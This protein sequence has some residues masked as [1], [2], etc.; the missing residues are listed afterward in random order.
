VDNLR[1]KVSAIIILVII[2][3]LLLLPISAF[4]LYTPNPPAEA[5]GYPEEQWGRLVAAMG[6]ENFYLH[7]DVAKFS[8]GINANDSFH[9]QPAGKFFSYLAALWGYC[10]T[11]GSIVAW[12]A[13]QGYLINNP[14]L[15]PSDFLD[16]Y[17]ENWYN[18]S[19]NVKELI[20]FANLTSPPSA[21]PPPPGET[22][23][24]QP[25]DPAAAP[26]PPDRMATSSSAQ[27]TSK[28]DIF[29]Y[30]HYG[31]TMRPHHF[32]NIYRSTVEE[33]DGKSYN[34]IVG[35]EGLETPTIQKW[36]D[37]KDYIFRDPIDDKIDPVANREDFETYMGHSEA[38]IFKVGCGSKGSK[39]MNWWMSCYV[40][41]LYVNW[42][43]TYKDG[44]L[45]NVP[46][47]NQFGKD[48]EYWLSG[49]GGSQY[50]DPLTAALVAEKYPQVL[51]LQFDIEAYATSKPPEDQEGNVA[52]DM[53]EVVITATT[54]SG[55]T[56]DEG[57]G[58]P[59]MAVTRLDNEIVNI[60]DCIN[61][62]TFVKD[63]GKNFKCTVDKPGRYAEDGI[64]A[65]E[66]GH[67]WEMSPEGFDGKSGV[68]YFWLCAEPYR[69]GAHAENIVTK[70]GQH[71]Q[72]WKGGSSRLNDL[73]LIKAFYKTLLDNRNAYSF[74]AKFNP[75]NWLKSLLVGLVKPVLTNSVMGVKR[76]I[77]DGSVW[78]T[79]EVTKSGDVV[80]VERETRNG[81]VIEIE[82]PEKQSAVIFLYNF[83]QRIAVI[84][85]ILVVLVIGLQLMKES[86]LSS[87]G[88][89]QKAKEALSRFT[90]FGLMVFFAKYI[91]LLVLYFN[92]ILVKAFWDID[93]FAN[94]DIIVHLATVGLGELIWICVIAIL[95]IL[96]ACIIFFAYVYRTAALCALLVLSPLAF[97]C[98]ILD[99][100]RQ[101]FQR[102]WQFTIS[103]VF[104]QFLHT[105]IY[106][107]FIAIWTSVNSIG[108]AGLF[109]TGSWIDVIS[110][111]LIVLCAMV[112]TLTLPPKIMSGAMGAG[113]MAMA[114]I[115]SKAVMKAAGGIAKIPGKAKNK[116]SNKVSKMRQQRRTSKETGP[117]PPPPGDDGPSPTTQAQREPR[118]PTPGGNPGH[119]PS[120]KDND[121]FSNRVDG[122]KGGKSAED[123][124]GDW[125]NLNNREQ[126]E[127]ASDLYEQA[128]G[129]GIVDEDHIASMVG[130]DKNPLNIDPRLSNGKAEINANVP[131][132]G[133]K[134]NMPYEPPPKRV[135]P[136]SRKELK[137]RGIPTEDDFDKS[138]MGNIKRRSEITPGDTAD[139]IKYNEK[140]RLPKDALGGES[141]NLHGGD[142]YINKS[143][144]LNND[145][146]R[147]EST[148]KGLEGKVYKNT[149]GQADHV[150]K[151]NEVKKDLGM[152]YAEKRQ[153]QKNFQNVNPGKDIPDSIW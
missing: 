45:P 58:I 108:G 5:P 81:T 90:I 78:I 62:V 121:D 27:A 14:Y 1:Q 4:G 110:K 63:T 43:R 39:H 9:R 42:F 52:E 31:G 68:N 152:K 97:L 44:S 119:V 59:G 11:H 123:L 132:P 103:T 16:M 53:T 34:K 93:F 143:G 116:I 100:T 22:P 117:T 48:T 13:Y 115:G 146:K 55:R 56:S 24:E 76:V 139:S 80:I 72:V 151:I 125:N 19:S 85:F 6:T 114:Y 2:A 98:G 66:G 95:L 29:S 138:E 105:I 60:Q 122:L 57:R 113:Q 67:C 47:W 96:G 17:D 12:P 41:D 23:Q 104:L 74:G 89:G 131:A 32:D 102:W 140:G 20:D 127:Y 118:T 147:V 38:I 124:D 136:P 137:Q 84:L 106:C 112:L 25:A 61:A 149:E 145:I 69:T 37:S 141:I 92:N 33:A 35:I 10:Q 101:Y 126:H 54:K 3:S 109:G 120:P 142:E 87:G 51:N 30:F 129:T 148:L 65:G 79:K 135:A 40:G 70:D 28:D 46:C 50:T 107:T 7:S 82:D 130:G 64:L 99:S 71:I 75:L 36:K 8:P 128:H 150:R 94:A 21:P 73:Y 83:V 15:L 49:T 86:F 111:Y 26:R 91:F 133:G 153:M 18:W 134:P 144:H 77:R 88:S